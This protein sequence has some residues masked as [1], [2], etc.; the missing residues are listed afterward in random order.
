MR[1]S[2]VQNNATYSPLPKAIDDV[3]ME[4]ASQVASHGYDA[5]HDDMHVFGELGQAGVSYA[6]AALGHDIT[7]ANSWPTFRGPWPFTDDPPPRRDPSDRGR[8]RLMVK[9][10]ALLVAEIERVDRRLTA[11]APP[12][13]SDPRTRLPG[14]AIED[15]VLVAVKACGCVSGFSAPR[16]GVMEPFMAE[17]EPGEAV[18]VMTDAEQRALPWRCPQHAAAY[19]APGEGA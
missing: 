4:R 2:A 16:P 12:P 6:L 1:I 18:Q 10:A 14:L 11:Q 13:S 17:L 9:A 15:A 3:W 19:Q 7:D 5:A 8:R